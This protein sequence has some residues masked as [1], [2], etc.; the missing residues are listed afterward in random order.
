MFRAD[1]ALPAL[2]VARTEEGPSVGSPTDHPITAGTPHPC[3]GDRVG[4]RDLSPACP[5]AATKSRATAPNCIANG[6]GR[7]P[8]ARNAATS[9]TSRDTLVALS[10]R[11][12][13]V[14]F[15]PGALCEVSVDPGHM[16]REIPDR[17]DPR[18]RLVVPAGI[19]RQFADQL[20][21]EIDHADAAIGDEQLD[22]AALVGAT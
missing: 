13:R 20:T 6:I 17:L 9:R 2:G 5:F 14:R 15:P 18:E 7:R 8:I 16:S 4:R 10:S 1:A 21:V 3:G 11:R 22:R 19:Q 12:P